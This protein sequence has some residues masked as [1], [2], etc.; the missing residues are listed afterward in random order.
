MQIAPL[1][2]EIIGTPQAFWNLEFGFCPPE[3][4]PPQ[5]ET[6]TARALTVQI[7][8]SKIQNAC[9]P[10]FLPLKVLF[11][12]LKMKEPRSTLLFSFREPPKFAAELVPE[13]AIVRILSGK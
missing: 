12:I 8:Q 1:S 3:A 9:C 7:S 6:V 11:T 2:S 5:A 13:R 10:A 4:D